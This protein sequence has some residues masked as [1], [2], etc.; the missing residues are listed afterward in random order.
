MEFSETKSGRKMV[1][2]MLL[3]GLHHILHLIPVA[4]DLEMHD[5]VDVIIYVRN[6]KEVQLCADILKA[7]GAMRTHI[8]IF[9]PHPLISWI[10]PKRSLVLSNI[11]IWRTLDI[12]IVAER[13]ST[14]LRRLFRRLPI[15]VHIPHGAGDRA[16][17]YDE[18]IARF[19]Y[20]LAA[21]SK[22]KRRMIEQDLVTDETCF[23]T[24]YIKPFAVNLIQ[25]E[26]P[27][28]F[29]NDNPVVLYNPHFET[30]LSSWRDFGEN[31]LQAF[32]Q[33]KEM[34]FI[35]A[36]HMRLFSGKNSPP[37]E[38][39]EKFKSNDNIL[40]DLGSERSADMT[41]TRV[42]DIYL[43]DV[44]S[45]VYEFLSVPKPCVFIGREDT[46]WDGNPD[47]AHWSYGPVCHSVAEVMTALSSADVDLPIYKD[48]Q[49]RGCR[50]AKG[51]PNWDPIKRASDVI[52]DILKT[53]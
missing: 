1:G 36:P 7:L 42:A 16:K 5:Y 27:K 46:N 44:S 34:N 10:Y 32:A 48:A 25:P 52:I 38:R 40:I 45:Q 31:L 37:K 2:L 28:L 3:G 41:Y 53:A 51:E 11:K 23:V 14:V 6:E 19:D 21:G 12:L 18:R 13:T 20:V 8:K 35:F 30:G 47:Y 43:G 15:L 22:D 50:A 24:G 39:V 49:E 33:Y 9:K 17:S 26:P 4:R 29:E